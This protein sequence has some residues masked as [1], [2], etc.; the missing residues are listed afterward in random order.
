MLYIG[1]DPS[2]KTGLVALDKDGQVVY[3]KELT[4]PGKDPARMSG[5]LDLIHYDVMR[6]NYKDNIKI[7]IEGFGFASQQG[8]L[9]GGIGWGIRCNLHNMGLTYIDV[10]PTSL[11]KFV[12]GKGNAKKDQVRLEVYKRW[13][14]EHKSDN[15]V[16]A[17]V[18]AQIAR[19]IGEGLTLT[20]FQDE[21]V[22]T[23]LAS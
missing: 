23:I 1:I 15:V 22:R 5:L 19:Y 9:L 17:Y 14:Y 21:V 16:D 20:K 7:A 10:A 3:A 6:L 8:F 2:T 11:K 13:G 18:L 4:M 12:G